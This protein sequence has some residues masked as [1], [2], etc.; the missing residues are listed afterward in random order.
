[1]QESLQKIKDK[2]IYYSLFIPQAFSCLK[3]FSL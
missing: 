2:K 3:V 1:V